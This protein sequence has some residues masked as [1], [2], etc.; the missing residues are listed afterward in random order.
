VLGAAVR[1]IASFRGRRFPRGA[2]MVDTDAPGH[3]PPAASEEA[4]T[5]KEAP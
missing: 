3:L 2:H 1:Y 5:L 4:A